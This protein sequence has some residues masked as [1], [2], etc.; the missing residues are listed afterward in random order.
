MTLTAFH[1]LVVLHIV[2]G[3]TAAIAFWVP[4]LGRKGG[5]AHRKAA[6][7]SPSRCCD[8][9][10]RDLHEPADAASTPWARI[11]HLVGRFD[12]GLRPRHL[13]LADAAPGILTVNL[14]WYGWLC[15]QHRRDRDAIARMAQH[16]AAAAA[17][18]GGA[19]LRAAGLADGQKLMIGLAIVGVA[20]GPTN[21][22]V[23]LQAASPARRTG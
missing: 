10:L 8:R 22:L 12:D 23:P 14:A 11:P 20:T 18:R 6:A 21:A 19:Q 4:V 3:T 15:A 2:T 9:Q 7:S 1:I 17:A 13:R 16:C 5:D